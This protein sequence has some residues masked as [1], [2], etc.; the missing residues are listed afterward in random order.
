[1]RRS[2]SAP[3]AAAYGCTGPLV[4]DRSARSVRVLPPRILGHGGRA[5]MIGNESSL[6]G[7]GSA[8]NTDFRVTLHTYAGPSA[9]M[10]MHHQPRALL[11]HDAARLAGGA[12]RPCFFV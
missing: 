8:V 4:A 3:S 11:L 1:M 9:G 6:I 7:T 5:R 10:R 2:R 12:K